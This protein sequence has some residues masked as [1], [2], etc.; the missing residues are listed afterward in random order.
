MLPPYLPSKF[1]VSN[2]SSSQESELRN[3]S[4]EY[5]DHSTLLVTQALASNRKNHS[6]MYEEAQ[7]LE[8]ASLF[9]VKCRGTR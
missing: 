6:E 7:I 8:S 5:E 9:K 4:E 1:G 2:A 3:K